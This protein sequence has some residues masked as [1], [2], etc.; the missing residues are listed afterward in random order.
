MHVRGGGLLC[1]V[2]VR[3]WRSV[4]VTS[5]LAYRYKLSQRLQLTAS[6]STRYELIPVPPDQLSMCYTPRHCIAIAAI[7][8]V[9]LAWGEFDTVGIVVCIT[10]ANIPGTER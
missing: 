7:S 9:E 10:T 5:I 3:T 4:I 2:H 6:R 1:C 8:H